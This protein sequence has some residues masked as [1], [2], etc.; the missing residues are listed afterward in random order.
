MYLFFAFIYL[1]TIFPLHFTRYLFPQTYLLLYSFQRTPLKMAMS[2]FPRQN[3][4]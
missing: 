1:C 2:V 3:S 4:T